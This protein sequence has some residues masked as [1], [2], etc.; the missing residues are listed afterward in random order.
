[1][2][3][4]TRRNQSVTRSAANVRGIGEVKNNAN[5]KVERTYLQRLSVG[6]EQRLYYSALR[7]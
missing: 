2:K 6:E 3:C 7:F 1:M 5:G 4:V